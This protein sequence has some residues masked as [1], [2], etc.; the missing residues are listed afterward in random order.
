[1]KITITTNDF[2][3]IFPEIENLYKQ[4]IKFK[5]NTSLK[6][7]KMYKESDEINS[8][9]L[10]RIKLVIPGLVDSG[11]VLTDTERDIYNTILLSPIEFDTY[12]LTIEELMDGCE[13]TVGVASLEKLLQVL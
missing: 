4:N 3:L 6:L 10:N 5:I 1:M 11:Y 8:Y 7:L 12:G 9:I 2:L 13:V